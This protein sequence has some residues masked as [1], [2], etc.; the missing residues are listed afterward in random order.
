MTEHTEPRRTYGAVVLALLVA[1]VIALAML[2]FSIGSALAE[3]GAPGAA[4]QSEPS[5]R[6]AQAEADPP[7]AAGDDCPFDR[8]GEDGGDGSGGGGDSSGSGASSGVS[9]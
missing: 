2:A 6:L 9:Y 5:Y 1:G 3:D 8:D 4:A 7:A